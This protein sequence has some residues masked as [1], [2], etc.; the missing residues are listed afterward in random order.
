MT[1]CNRVTVCLTLHQAGISEEEIAHHLQ[2]QAPSVGFYIRESYSK[3]GDLTQK[4]V[5]SAALMT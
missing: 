2:W 5:A 4:A 1:H 3:L